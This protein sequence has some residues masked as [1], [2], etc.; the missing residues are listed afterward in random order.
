MK[1]FGVLAA[2]TCLL[3]VVGFSTG[4]FDLDRSQAT[5]IDGTNLVAADN[6]DC[7][8]GC[9]SE[10]QSVTDKQ[11]CCGGCSEAATAAKTSCCQ[12]AAASTVSTPSSDSTETPCD[13]AC[14]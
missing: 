5:D 14:A 2:A 9:C 12:D 6:Q 13:G 4:A 7:C 1:L 10:E 8:G 3:V 11:E